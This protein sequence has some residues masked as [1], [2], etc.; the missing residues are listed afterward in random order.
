M[1][2]RYV[3]AV[4][5]F[6][7]RELFIDGIFSMCGFAQMPVSVV[8][9]DR[10]P[11]NYTL[12]RLLSMAINGITSFSTRPLIG[13][14][15]M[16]TAV[17]ALALSYTAVIVAQKLVFGVPVAGWSSTMAAILIIGGM[18]IF[19]NGIIAIYLAKVFYEVKQRP[20]AIV[21]EAYRVRNPVYSR[22][23]PRCPEGRRASKMYTG[24]RHTPIWGEPDP[25]SV[26]A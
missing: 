25:P 7:E 8:K 13:I 14:A 6:K 3:D 20:H 10:S 24:V 12:V 22:G 4:L 26:T 5:Q 9:Y 18:N 21:K 15:V 23:F 16:G 19:A 2:R 1:R 11:T 17:C